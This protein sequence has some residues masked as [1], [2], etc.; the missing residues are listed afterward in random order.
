[1]TLTFR[2]W[3]WVRVLLTKTLDLYL[4]SNQIWT[5]C[6][7]LFGKYE[8]L[9]V[10]VLHGTNTLT[11]V[12]QDHIRTENQKIICP[13]HHPM[14]GHKNSMKQ[15]LPDSWAMLTCYSSYCSCCI[16]TSGPTC[17]KHC[18]LNE[19]VSG[20][21]VLVSTISNSQI[22]L[23]KKM[24]ANHIFSAKMLAYMPYLMIKVLTIR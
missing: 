4:W 19:L 18:Y 8:L 5:K 13:R 24:W 15:N 9:K 1:M 21:I 2:S 10:Q 17:S 20:Q 11:W 12:Q 14:R 3:A 16:F 6:M 23:L 22:F 7:R